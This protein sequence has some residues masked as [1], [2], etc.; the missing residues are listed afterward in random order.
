MP[1]LSEKVKLLH[2]EFWEERS[3][4]GIK[5]SNPSKFQEKLEF[6]QK[7]SELQSSQDPRVSAGHGT[8]PRKRV[9]GLF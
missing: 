7:E 9:M 2:R 8:H 6:A 4:K 5:Q 3:P 1:A